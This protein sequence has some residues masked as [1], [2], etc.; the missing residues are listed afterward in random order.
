MAVDPSRSRAAVITFGCKVNQCESAFLAASLERAGWQVGDPE[1]GV[2]LVVVNTCTVTAAADRQARQLLRRL[3]RQTPAPAVAVTGCYAQR[4][5]A[6]LQNLPGVAWVLGQRE[7]LALADHLA[8]PRPGSGSVVRVGDLHLAGPA[9]FPPLDAFPGHTRA[10]LKVQDGCD[11]HCSYCIVPRVRGPVR[12]LPLAQVREQ[13]ARLAAAGFPELVLTG[14]HLG[15]YGSDLP[16]RPDLAALV[17]DLAAAALPCRVRLSSLEPPEVTPELLS[18]LA[19]WPAF[20][21]HFHLPLQS[22][23]A[24]VLAAMQRPYRPEDYRD[25]IHRLAALFPDAAL[26]CDVMVGFPGETAADFAATLALLESLPLAYL[27]VFP[28]SRRPG[29]LAATF[30]G[31]LPPPVLKDRARLLRQLSRSLKLRF[32]D[33]QVGAL[34]QVVV[35]GT[36]PGHSGCLLGLSANYLRVIFPGPA[37]WINTVRRVRLLARRGDHLLAAPVHDSEHEPAV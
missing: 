21:P 28:Y 12:S 5:P 30:P 32:L 16:G 6:E 1:A 27:H 34:A 19:S 31:L 36:A 37:A 26:G 8:A 14:I 23:A 7:K 18:R 2:R 3:A 17:G 13:A 33:R 20:C 11:Q 22:G 35:E 9:V 24:P 10:F 25:L 15:R 29:T 4:A